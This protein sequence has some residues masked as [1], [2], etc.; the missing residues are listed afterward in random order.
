[1][2]GTLYVARFK[3]D[4]TGAWIELSLN[5]PVIAN[6]ASFTFKTDADVAIFTR[7]AADTVGA[8]KMDRPEWGGVNPRNG[9]IYFTLTNNSKRTADTTDAANPRVYS[10][11]KGS[12]VQKGNV[13]GHILRMAQARPTDT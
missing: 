9:E 4:G 13:N 7:L 6:N 10:D 3:D 11:Q 2:E 12:K 1:D 8:T 5:N